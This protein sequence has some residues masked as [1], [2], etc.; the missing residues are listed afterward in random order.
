MSLVTEECV[1]SAFSTWRNT[2]PSNGSVNLGK[3]ADQFRKAIFEQDIDK[4]PFGGRL[5]EK[6]AERNHIV[7]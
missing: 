7:A 3:C 5:F 6:L 1:E 4:L 2:A